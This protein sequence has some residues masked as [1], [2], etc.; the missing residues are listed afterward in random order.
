[1]LLFTMASC[2]LMKVVK[3]CSVRSGAVVL[4]CAQQGY[5]SDCR[6]SH[7]DQDWRL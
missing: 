7:A 3:G 2:M 4:F 6:L 1:M 5:M